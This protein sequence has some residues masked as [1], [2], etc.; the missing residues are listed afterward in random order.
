MK[1]RKLSFSLLIATIC[2]S[3]KDSKRVTEH[4]VLTVSLVEKQISV[5]DL[6]KDITIIPLETVEESSFRYS[7]KIE[8]YDDTIYVFDSSLNSLYT[9]APNGKYVRK[10]H[11]VGQGPGEYTMVCDFL[12]NRSDSL[13]ELLH[14]MGFIYKYKTNGTFVRKDDLPKPPMNYMHF[15]QLDDRHYVTWSL[16]EDEMGGV[17]TLS[18]DNYQLLN[19]YFPNSGL[20]GAFRLNSVFHT[21]D[22]TTFYHESMANKVYRITP[23]GY[24]IAYEWDFGMTIIDPKRLVAPPEN[25]TKSL[26]ALGQEFKEGKIPFSIAKQFQTDAYYYASLRFGLSLSDRKSL[27]YNKA[28][29]E[30]M[31]FKKTKEGIRIDPAFITNHY[32][33]GRLEYEDKEALRGI[34]SS[35]DAEILNGMNEDDN[36]W[37]MKFLFK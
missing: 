31:L 2:L 11:Q 10:I 14:P 25:T 35:K 3:C 33:I 30:S 20:W 4:P 37:L 15:E 5:Y 9:F 6:F 1:N 7:E 32:I 21:Y 22:N 27:F 13:I 34:V 23:D 16:Q 19:S 8:L 28:T 24:Q 26:M 18:S 36:V 17:N 12:I 29:G